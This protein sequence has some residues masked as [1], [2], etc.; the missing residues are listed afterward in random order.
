MYYCFWDFLAKNILKDKIIYVLQ[1]A[2]NETFVI[3]LIVFPW[4]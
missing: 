1:F 2:L 3:K 4:E